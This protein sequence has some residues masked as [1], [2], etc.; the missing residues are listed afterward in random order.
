MGKSK[1]RRSWLNEDFSTKLKVDSA[2]LG[3]PV[4][5]YT[6]LLTNIDL[7]SVASQ[8]LQKRENETGRKKKKFVW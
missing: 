7:K 3:I 4:V 8:E 2:Q 1:L 5:K 6:E